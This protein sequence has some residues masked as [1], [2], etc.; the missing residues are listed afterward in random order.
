MASEEDREPV[1][2]LIEWVSRVITWTFLGACAGLL[3]IVVRVLWV[4]YA[5]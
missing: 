3:G 2:Q 4:R 1:R 5:G